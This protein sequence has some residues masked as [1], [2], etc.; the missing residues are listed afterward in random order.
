MI[1]KKSKYTVGGSNLAAE[2]VVYK[3]RSGKQGLDIKE[4]RRIFFVVG[5]KR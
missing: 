5:E 3:K 4:K 2:K 1:N